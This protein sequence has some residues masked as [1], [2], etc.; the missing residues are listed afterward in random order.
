MASVRI[1]ARV[2]AAL[3]AES[4][5]GE[6][7]KFSPTIDSEIG[8]FISTVSANNDISLSVTSTEGVVTVASSKAF[9]SQDT[10]ASS[11]IDQAVKRRV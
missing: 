8:A 9:S 11:G 5:A 3:L 4:I 1:R 6:Q 2:I 7:E 10:A